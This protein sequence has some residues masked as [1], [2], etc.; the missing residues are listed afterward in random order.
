MKIVVVL[1]L[2]MLLSCV[3]LYGIFKRQGIDGWKAFV[4][5]LN[6]IEWL[7]L[8][9]KPTWWIA[10]LLIPG[11][12]IFYMASMLSGLARA[13][14]HY[15]FPHAAA[16]ILTPFAYLP[17]LGFSKNEKYHGPEGMNDGFV[18]PKKNVIRE[19][20]DAAVFAIVAAHL[21]RIF[22]IEAYKIPTSSMEPTLQ[23]GDFMFI[24]KAHYGSRIPNTPLGLPFLH[25]SM[26]GGKKR[27]YSEA[28]KLPYKRLPGIQKVKRNDIV[29][30]NVPFEHDMQSDMAKNFYSGIDYDG[31]PVD[32][33]EHYI[34]HAVGIPG[35]V[36]EVK[37]RQLYIN[38][39][40]AENPE[41][42]QFRYNLVTT[43]RISNAA[44][45]EKG[46]RAFNHSRFNVVNPRWATSGKSAVIHMT[47]EVAEEVAKMPFVE[48]VTLYYEGINYGN[49]DFPSNS[50]D[51][52][53]NID[54]YG[55]ITIPKKGQSI[56]IT[57][58]NFATYRTIMEVHEGNEL[59]IKGGKLFVNGEQKDSYTF[60]MDYYWLMGDNRHN[61]LDSRSWGFV[62]EDHVV[63]KPLFV[64][65]SSERGKENAGFKWNRTLKK[66]QDIN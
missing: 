9:G 13:H 37:D 50:A 30:F 10:M 25:H 32:K 6:V 62:P 1:G 3:G 40:E 63:G 60:E 26:P 45:R 34:K 59:E 66:A 64:V 36:L 14:R 53:W 2:I 29:V 39:E 52:G 5:F 61:S 49:T 17:F 51:L 41:T 16:S 24:S 7:K 27:A 43:E 56:E 23:V 35:D 58:E 8:I 33:R 11:V 47:P 21:I 65:Y 44:L 54:N 12:N 20:V 22:F 31:R 18:P 15:S 57:N 55:P 4:P 42:L 28:I 48:S 19:W 38:G 46:V